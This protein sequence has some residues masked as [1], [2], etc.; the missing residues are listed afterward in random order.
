[1]DLSRCPKPL[2]LP[3]MCGKRRVCSRSSFA[4]T[5]ISACCN[6]QHRAR[7]VNALPVETHDTEL[8]LFMHCLLQHTTQSSCCFRLCIACWNT[9]HQARVVC[10]LP[11]E[12]TTQSLCCL[13]IACWITRHRARVAYALPVASHSTELKLFMLMHNDE[14]RRVRRSHDPFA[15]TAHTGIHLKFRLLQHSLYN[16]VLK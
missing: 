9:R 16:Q 5:S 10:A 14:E 11:V 4:A 12:H 8:V 7:V 15:S 1:M 13:C 6:T 3:C 2:S